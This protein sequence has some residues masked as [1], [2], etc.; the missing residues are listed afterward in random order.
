[1]NITIEKNKNEVS[2]KVT[3]KG[4]DCT[5]NGLSTDNLKQLR[6]QIDEVLKTPK[7]TVRVWN[8]RS[9]KHDIIEQ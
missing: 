5:F 7:A 1:M 9:G 4:V 6:E 8:P 3:N 2:L